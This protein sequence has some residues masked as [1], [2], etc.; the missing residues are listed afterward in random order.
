MIVDLL[1]PILSIAGQTL[2]PAILL[3]AVSLDVL[4]KL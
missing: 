3:F 2:N 1:S 4:K